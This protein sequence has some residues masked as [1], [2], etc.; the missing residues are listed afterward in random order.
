MPQ[1]K[2]AA[3]V[4]FVPRVYDMSPLYRSHRLLLVPSVVEDAF[5]RLIIEAALHGTPSIGTDRGGISE[6]IGPGGIVNL[7]RPTRP[8]VEQRLVHGEQLVARV[9]AAVVVELQP[10]EVRHALP[11]QPARAVHQSGWLQRYDGPAS[12]H[13]R[14][15]PAEVEH[16]VHPELHLCSRRDLLRVR[17]NADPVP[18]QEGGKLLARPQQ[19]AVPQVTRRC[20][21]CSTAVQPAFNAWPLA[22]ALLKQYAF[23]AM[24]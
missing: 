21:P 6:A 3:N 1:A 13:E 20:G 17:A 9:V 23:V 24:A 10:P 16:T 11:P 18:V 7:I 22:D 2:A 5:P 19:V 12:V 14:R 8:L 4:T 15:H